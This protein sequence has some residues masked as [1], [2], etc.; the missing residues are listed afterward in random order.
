MGPHE[1][2]SLPT[3]KTVSSL[4]FGLFAT[5]TLLRIALIRYWHSVSPRAADMV[6]G[7][8]YALSGRGGTVFVTPLAGHM[9]E[10]LSVL[11][12]GFLVAGMLVWARTWR[13]WK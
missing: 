13:D 12:L 8:T 6:T 9:L 5:G 11:P 4:C 1:T 3:Q 2:N 10:T 7:H